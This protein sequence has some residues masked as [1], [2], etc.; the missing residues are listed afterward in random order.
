[1]APNRTWFE[2]ADVR[3]RRFSTSV[4]IPLRQSETLTSEGRVNEPGHAEELLCVGSIAVP[5]ASREIGERLGWHDLGHPRTAPYAFEDGS[6]K[7]AEVYQFRDKE[8]A[9]QHLVLV[10]T[11]VG[12]AP[13]QWLVDQDLVLAL[14]LIQEGN[15]WVRPSEGYVEVI[16]QRISEDGTFKA[17]EIKAEFLRDYLAAT[18]LALRVG[19]YRQR[20]AI[21]GSS[22]WQSSRRLQVNRLRVGQGN[23]T[24]ARF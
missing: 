8:N 9:G 5:L 14:G 6:Y 23:G 11:D 15:S 16:R 19:M 22:V 1:M 12:D 13:S 4:W 7:R 10:H 17:I 2:M 18:Q 3:R 20:M 24:S 21:L